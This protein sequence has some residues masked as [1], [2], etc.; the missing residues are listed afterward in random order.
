MPRWSGLQGMACL[1]S[2]HVAVS[3]AAQFF[4]DEG[5]QFFQRAFVP[6]APG[7]EQRSDVVRGAR[8][9]A[10]LKLTPRELQRG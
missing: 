5:R 2:R 1:L 7:L 4:V 9:S 8:D 6:G 3:S 10:R